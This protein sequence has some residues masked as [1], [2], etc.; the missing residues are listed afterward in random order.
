MSK[1]EFAKREQW[2]V[3]FPSGGIDWKQVDAGRFIF[4]VLAKLWLFLLVSLLVYSIVG[5][6]NV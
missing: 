3:D 1:D 5:I 2:R 6:L 4:F